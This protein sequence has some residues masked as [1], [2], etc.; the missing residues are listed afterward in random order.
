MLNINL[1]DKDAAYDAADTH[2]VT[3]LKGSE[4]STQKVSASSVHDVF[5]NRPNPLQIAMQFDT[6][7]PLQNQGNL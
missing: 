2:C 4:W 3:L 5:I 1:A 6:L 7:D